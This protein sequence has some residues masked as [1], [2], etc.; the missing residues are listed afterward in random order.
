MIL[1][2]W[3][4]ILELQIGA[5]VLMGSTFWHST[6]WRIDHYQAIQLCIGAPQCTQLVPSATGL[7]GPQ[8]PPLG[9]RDQCVFLASWTAD[10][11]Y[12]HHKHSQTNALWICQGQLCNANAVAEAWASA[13]RPK[14]NGGLAR[15]VPWWKQKR[16]R[17][18][19]KLK[20]Q[21][22]FRFSHF[23]ISQ[24]SSKFHFQWVKLCDFPSFTEPSG[25]WDLIGGLHSCNQT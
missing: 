4:C 24:T 19:L 20:P 11:L 1:R 16:P 2:H 9:R 12:T 22:C 5:T 14:R 25:W 18:R 15:E 3:N 13:Q 6:S 21:F 7:P 23:K 17:G 10:E 8:L